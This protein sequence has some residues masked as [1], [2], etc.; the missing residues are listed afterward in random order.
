M[1][2]SSLRRHARELG[3]DLV[4]IAPADPLEG[5]QFY[6]RWLALGYAGEM[7]YLKRHLDR[8]HDPRK[9]V[10]GARSVICV[11]MKY[12]QPAAPTPDALS[13]T[14][15][16]YARG[17]DYHDVVKARLADLWHYVVAAAGNAPRGRCYV[18]TAPVLERE[19]ASRAGLGWRGKNTCLINSRQ[20]SFF[21]LGEIITDLVLEYDQPAVARCGT[22]TRCLE[23][24]PT[25]AFPEP[26]LLDARRCLSYL[27]IEHRG[28]I[29]LALRSKLGN[30]VLGCDV[31]Q[32]VCPWNRRVTRAPEPA[33]APR[34]GLDPAS[35]IDLLRLDAEAFSARFRRHPAK[36]PK[37]RGLL[38][39]VAVAL[40]NSGCQEAVPHLVRALT[41]AEPLIRSHAAW[42]LGQL[43]GA[44]AHRG[45]SHALELE[46]DEEVMQEIQAALGTLA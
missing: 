37:R 42:A 6:A 20:G 7:E 33:F 9:L 16:C 13:G 40:G 34:E 27:T 3:F 45:L 35:L 14:L 39:N 5:V 36:R 43:G 8:R 25:E 17:D 18:D 28:P 21:F 31:C 2:T 41:D 15:A 11:G 44:E 24:C 26:Y 30:R 1:L 4:G 46:S 10:A 23:A 38:R 32:D 19:L 22:C 12:H 29:P